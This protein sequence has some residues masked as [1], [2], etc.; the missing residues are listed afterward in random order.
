MQSPCWSRLL[1]GPADQWRRAHARAG[2]LAG[3]VTSRGTQMEQPVP[4]GFH[5]VE[6]T[7]VG[8]I[9]DELQ[10]VARTHVGEDHGELYPM[11]GTSR[12]SRGRV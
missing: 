5:P 3:L 4:E 10:P 11:R 6:V 7:H 1:P 12:W 8:A 9:H 2:L